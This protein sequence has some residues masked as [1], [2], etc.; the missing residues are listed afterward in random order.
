MPEN[1]P[2]NP[3]EETTLVTDESIT[4]LLPPNTQRDSNSVEV[5]HLPIQRVLIPGALTLS[6]LVVPIILFFSMQPPMNL[7]MAFTVA[8]MEF[9]VAAFMY[10]LFNSTFVRADDVGLTR[11]QLGQKQSVRW[12]EIVSMG[13]MQIGNGPVKMEFKNAS[14]KVIFRCSNLGNRVDGEKLWDFIDKKL[15]KP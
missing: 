14:D 2:E 1:S 8:I 15:E 9:G 3:F 12:E 7:M 4:Y 13:A 10:F 6:G 5:R 11:S